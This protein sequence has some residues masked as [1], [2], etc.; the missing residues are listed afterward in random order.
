MG[1]GDGLGL[2]DRAGDRDAM[3][4]EISTTSR[5]YQRG[6][7]CGGVNLHGGF[8]GTSFVGSGVGSGGVG[9][10][11]GGSSAHGHGSLDVPPTPGFMSRTPSATPETT[12]WP[13]VQTPGAL[14]QPHHHH[15]HHSLLL[16]SRNASLSTT[17]AEEQMTTSIVIPV[18]IITSGGGQSKPQQKGKNKK[19][20]GSRR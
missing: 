3:L 17:N 6:S 5:S 2:G 14:G 20:K 1:G 18:K 9:G 13:I 19:S 12:H 8:G 16:E 7:G 11:G 10:V 15:H 4:D